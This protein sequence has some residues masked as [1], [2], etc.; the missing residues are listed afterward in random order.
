MAALRHHFA[1]NMGLKR[2][3]RA[4]DKTVTLDPNVKWEMRKRRSWRF[5]NTVRGPV[6]VGAQMGGDGE[7]CRKMQRSKRAPE[8]MTSDLIMIKALSGG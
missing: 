2:V 4:F 7:N 1:H 6:F 5:S 3:R 8:T